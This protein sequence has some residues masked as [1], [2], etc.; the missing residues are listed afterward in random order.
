MFQSHTRN[1]DQKTLEQRNRQVRFGRKLHVEVMERRLMLSAAPLQLQQTS[2]SVD[3]VSTLN[4]NPNEAS[5][6]IS[7]A[8]NSS[9]GGLIN[10]DATVSTIPFNNYLGNANDSNVSAAFGRSTVD[11]LFDSVGLNISVAAPQVFGEG[12]QPWV[13]RSPESGLGDASRY[14]TLLRPD[15]TGADEGG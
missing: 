9:D 2:L 13:I 8:S 6:Q 15:K 4:I 10:V 1:R 12:L 3:L 14:I 11:Q 7:F 5:G